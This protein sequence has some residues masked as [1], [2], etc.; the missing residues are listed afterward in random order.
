MP[1]I[2][3]HGLLYRGA[4]VPN[5]IREIVL[6]RTG[7]L[8]DWPTY[9]IPILATLIACTWVIKNFSSLDIITSAPT[10]LSFSL[11]CSPYGWFH[12]H[13]VLVITQ[14]FLIAFSYDKH[15]TQAV[16]QKIFSIVYGLQGL[17]V[18]AT[19]FLRENQY[20]VWFPFA[21]FLLWQWGKKH[22]SASPDRHSS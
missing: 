19:Y 8:I 4:T 3:E 20:L 17:T 22:F 14:I 13:S 1:L 18:I 16:R 11:L 7:T 10:F 5:L 12:G 15:V 21:M 2:Q 9:V 6:W